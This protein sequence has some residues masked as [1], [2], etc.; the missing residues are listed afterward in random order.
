LL[1]PTTLDAKQEKEFAMA[2]Q[3]NSAAG[4][5]HREIKLTYEFKVK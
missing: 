2:Y 5:S 3:L 1:T 4:L